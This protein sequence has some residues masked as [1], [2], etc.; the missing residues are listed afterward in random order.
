MGAWKMPDQEKT[1]NHRRDIFTIDFTDYLPGALK[2]DPK[3]RALA[4]A[5]TKAALD[6]SGNIDKVLIYSRIDEL[7]EGLIDILAYDMHVDWYDY[8]Y[9]LEIKR[10]LVK[11]SVK[12]HKKMGTVYAVE[13]A[14]RAIYPES[15]IEEWF[16]YGG[17]PFHFRVILNAGTQNVQIDIEDMMKK[18]NIYKRLSAHMDSIHTE[19]T[20][21]TKIYAAVSREVFVKTKF[22]VNPYYKTVKKRIPL[23]PGICS[24]R[25]LWLSY[26]IGNNCLKY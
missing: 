4:A 19:R 12:V 21:K 24:V 26:P 7:P 16:E 5:V 15:R 22:H 9:P 25:H 2:H 1:L 8:A 17:K 3:M 23:K 18:I 6:V 14:I 20:K 11:S 13:T 10:N